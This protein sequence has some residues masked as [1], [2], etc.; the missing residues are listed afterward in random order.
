MEATVFNPAQLQLLEMMSFVKSEKT[1][2]DLKQVI[3]DYFASQAQAEIDRLWDEGF[4]TEE[5]VESFRKLHERT[6]Y[7]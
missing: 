1:L 7:N 4:L 6:P 5:K 2:A 3:S